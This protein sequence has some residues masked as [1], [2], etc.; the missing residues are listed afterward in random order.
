M[1]LLP[2]IIDVRVRE[3]GN[4]GFR[5]WLPFFLLWPLV[6]PIF[7]LAFM[8]SCVADLALI[9]A[10]ARYHH[11]TALLL[12]TV[13]LFAEMRGTHAHIVDSD[14]FVHVDII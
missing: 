6:L 10:G 2:M 1:L 5:L 9:V 3:E 8:V 12:G 4:R 13:R 14:S 7:A 11:Y